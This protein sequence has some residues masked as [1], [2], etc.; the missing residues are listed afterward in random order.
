MYFNLYPTTSMLCVKKKTYVT[1]VNTIDAFFAQFQKMSY[2]IV[3]FCGRKYTGLQQKYH[4]KF[5]GGAINP[6]TRIMVN[7]TYSD[8]FLAF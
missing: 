8:N 7:I 5:K 2:Y 3:W 6:P 4:P 1:I